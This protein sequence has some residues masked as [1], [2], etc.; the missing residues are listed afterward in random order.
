M[1]YN[2]MAQMAQDYLLRQRLYACAG[3]EGIPNSQS[4]VDQNIWQIVANSEFDQ[5]YAYAVGTK[6]PNPGQD[7][8]VITDAVI[9]AHV[10][11]L[12]PQP[13]AGS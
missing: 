8:G 7:E 3:S 4:W 12:K 11:P 6:V 9:L 2:T 5:A 13:P 1:S 10:Q